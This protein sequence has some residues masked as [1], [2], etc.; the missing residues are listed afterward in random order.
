LIAEQRRTK[1]LSR[2]AQPLVLTL[3]NA[4]APVNNIYPIRSER[5]KPLLENPIT[6]M[7]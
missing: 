7:K 3:D 4:F 5:E 1:A 6:A 2:A